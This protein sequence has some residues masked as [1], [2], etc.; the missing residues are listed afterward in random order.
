MNDKNTF[1]AEN[2]DQLTLFG[3]IVAALLVVIIGIIAWEVPVLWACVLVL[4][5]AGLAVCM[6]KVPIWL[7]AVVVIAQVIVG[8]FFGTAMFLLFC[9]VFYMVGILALNV[10]NK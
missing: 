3:V 8:V 2:K 9:A 10:W 1:I 4:L 7:H 5:E 6:Q